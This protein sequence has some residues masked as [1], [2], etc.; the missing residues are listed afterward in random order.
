MSNVYFEWVRSKRPPEYDK[1]Y[2]DKLYHFD[3]GNRYGNKDENGVT[4]YR[5]N[6]SYWFGDWIEQTGSKDQW[7]A[8]G[9][10]HRAIY[11][12]RDDFMSFIELKWL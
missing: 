5:L 12:V 6:C 3:V 2:G 4:W 10:R 8:Y 11:I 7:Y 1:L 9:A